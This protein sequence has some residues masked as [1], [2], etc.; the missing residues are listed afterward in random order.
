MTVHVKITAHS[1]FAA[2]PTVVVPQPQQ[3]Q[4]THPQGEP[5]R[6]TLRLVR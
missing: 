5:N 6:P 4:Q 2:P 1:G 3:V